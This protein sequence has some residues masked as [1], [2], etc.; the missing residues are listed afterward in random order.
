M[1]AVLSD[2][3]CRSLQNRRVNR[4]VGW[5]L[6]TDHLEP[7]KKEFKLFNSIEQSLLQSIAKCTA[8]NRY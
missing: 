1:I 4:N 3:Y 5:A 7:E 6:P 2:Y 8:G